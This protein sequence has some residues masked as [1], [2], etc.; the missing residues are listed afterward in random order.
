MI[1]KLGIY[2]ILVCGALVWASE[3]FGLPRLGS[4]ALILFG[5]WVAANGVGVAL[6]GQAELVNPEQSR[7]EFL[8]GVPEGLW[9]AIFIT[10]G[11]GLIVFG[12][13]DLFSPGGAERFL[14]QALNS[15]SGTGVLV[16]VIGLMVAANGVISLLSGSAAVTGKVGRL[17]EFEFRASAIWH[18]LVGTLMLSLALALILV[19]GWLKAVFDFIVA[20][21]KSWILSRL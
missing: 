12:G 13:M 9:S 18:V 14:S 20:G 4:I 19:P 8:S 2:T 15:P 11:L 10:V 21:I 17:E 1:N 7:F 5:L 16:G 6:K 3:Y